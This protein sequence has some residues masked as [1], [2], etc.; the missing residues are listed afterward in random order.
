MML[1]GKNI[2]PKRAKRMGLVDQLVDPNA[3][4]TAAI[5]AAKVVSM[6]CNDHTYSGKEL[7]NGS[8]K[9]NRE[10]NITRRVMEDTP[11]RK[12]VF[13]KVALC[14][15]QIFARLSFSLCGLC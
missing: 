10:K 13:K 2:Q 7:A 15:C 14:R 4:E 11:V 8:R 3:L 9:I 12:L 5:Q 6:N 1:T